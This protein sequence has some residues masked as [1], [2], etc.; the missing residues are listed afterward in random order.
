[1]PE[2]ELLNQSAVGFEIGVSEVRQEPAPGPDHFEPA[3]AAVMVF[4]MVPEM[5]GERVDPLSE[6]GYLQPGRPGVFA[7][8]AV[9]GDY[10]LLVVRHALESSL[11]PSFDVVNAR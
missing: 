10:R 9:F 3:S 6:K 11:L 8:E 2:S 7:V 1:M 4:G 5:I